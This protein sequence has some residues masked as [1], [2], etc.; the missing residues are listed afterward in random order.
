MNRAETRNLNSRVFELLASA[1]VFMVSA[2]I[3]LY[4][5]VVSSSQLIDRPPTVRLRRFFTAQAE[6]ILSGRLWIDRSDG[7][8]EC[9]VADDQCY[10]Y[11]GL[12]PSLL[13]IPFLSVANGAGMTEFFVIVGLLAGI[14]GSLMLVHVIF[15]GILRGLDSGWSKLAFVSALVIAGPGNLWVQLTRATGYEE[16]IVWASTFSTWGLVALVL[17]WRTGESRWLGF[18]TLAFVLGANSRPSV[19]PLAIAAATIVAVYLVA[20]RKTLRDSRAVAWIVSMAVLPLVSMVG[21]WFA[22]FGTFVPSLA[23][24]ES[25]LQSSKW[26]RVLSANGGHDSWWGFI[27]TN[28]V[29]YLRPDSLVWADGQLAAVRPGREDP[30]ILPP[31]EGMGIFVTP[32]ASVTALVPVVVLLI[33]VALWRTPRLLSALSP[34]PLPRM[35]SVGIALAG[36]APIALLAINAGVQNRYMG[37]LAPAIAVTAAFGCVALADARGINRRVR[38]LLVVAIAILAIAGVT[39]GVLFQTWQLARFD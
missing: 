31:L 16:A 22:K 38:P 25:V 36:W 33:A 29:Q 15:G 13:R 27:P 6:A 9:F 37:D 23:I 34:E 26:S 32:M 28:L 20:K 14:A 18:A 8:G 24:N 3:V 19:V 7:A 17:W 39:I 11:F 4:F 30:L 21:V 2:A 12:T 35:V 1:V 5:S 10:G